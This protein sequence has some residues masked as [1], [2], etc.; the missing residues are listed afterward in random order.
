MNLKDM[1]KARK[2]RYGNTKEQR[3]KGENDKLKRQISSL[4]KQIARLDLDR[5]EVIKDL[6][7]EHS[8]QDNAEQGKEILESLKKTWACHDCETG[9][10][11][12]FVYNRG[13]ET[14]YYRI[15]SNAPN[16][17]KRTKSQLYSLQVKGLVRK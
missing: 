17:G 15:C 2:D 3:L 11:E 6:I 10:L 5:Y 7:E 14:W 16:C 4:R 8:T 12:M 13:G 9:Y 1:S